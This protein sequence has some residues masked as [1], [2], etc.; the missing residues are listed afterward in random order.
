MIQAATQAMRLAGP[1]LAAFLSSAGAREFGK[2]VGKNIL[3]DTAINTGAQQVLPRVLG[4]RPRPL[5]ESLIQSVTAAALGAPVAT[6]LS[7]AGVNPILGSLVATGLTAG[8]AQ[9]IANSIIEPETHQSPH[10]PYEE[11]AA[12]QQA[13][14]LSE[15]EYYDKQIALAYA[16]NY[17]TPTEVYHHSFNPSAATDFAARVGAQMGQTHRYL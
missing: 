17:K 3:I 7:R 14:A 1:K 2:E 8:P 4:G 15:R 6:G 12:S 13:E 5:A 10:R 11:L 16:Q 9:K